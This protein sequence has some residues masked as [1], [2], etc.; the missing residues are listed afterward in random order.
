MSEPATFLTTQEYQRF[1]EFADAVRRDRY[2]GLCYGPPGVG[3]TL[4]ARHYAHWDATVRYLAHRQRPG[5][6]DLMLRP[7]EGLDIAR[8]VFWTAPVA[9]TAAQISRNVLGWC[10]QVDR[11][12][13]RMPKG[14]RRPPGRGAFPHVEL[15]VVDEADRLKTTGLEQLRDI[16]DQ[17]R[18]GLVLI[19]MPGLQRR[20]ARY[21]QLYSRVGFAHEYRPLSHGELLELLRHHAL[22]LGLHLPAEALTDPDALAAIVRITGGNLRLVQRLFAQINRIAEINELDTITRDVV[23]TAR[24]S[25]IIGAA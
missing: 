6:D 9:V 25:L 2:I 17:H 24:E 1:A 18:I 4:S 15:I 13:R 10:E 20:L 19:G 7:P 3:K 23:D 22:D 8:T 21:P 5:T 16:Y 12:I 11:A 14:W